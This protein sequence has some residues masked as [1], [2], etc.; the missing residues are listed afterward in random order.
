MR[1]QEAVEANFLAPGVGPQRG[2]GTLVL[3]RCGDRVHTGGYVIWRLRE[4]VLAWVTWSQRRGPRGLVEVERGG[5]WL[6]RG[7]LVR[8]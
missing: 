3:G 8:A 6:A 7:H 2:V 5:R 1:H 4:I